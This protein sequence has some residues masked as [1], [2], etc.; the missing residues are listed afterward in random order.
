MQLPGL[1]F[2]VK[3]EFN[4]VRAAN[5]VLILITS[6]AL[7]VLSHLLIFIHKE[8]H[9]QVAKVVLIHLLGAACLWY[10]FSVIE[11]QDISFT[12][13]ETIFTFTS[14]LVGLYSS[15]AIY[16]VVFHP[17]RRLPGP[18]LAPL[19]KI[20][21]V[22]CC[23]NKK[24]YQILDNWYKKYGRVVRI[25]KLCGIALLNTVVDLSKG[26]T[27]LLCSIQLHWK[28]SMAR[29]QVVQLPLGTIC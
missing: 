9:L 4:I 24:N 21:H 13:Q 11:P 14:Y 20:Y 6:L 8:W 3:I 7:G 2:F 28:L 5:M 15:I 17:L 19:T 26:R 27:R 22:W 18:R 16:R 25:G 29:A 12:G 1:T 23:R 10:A